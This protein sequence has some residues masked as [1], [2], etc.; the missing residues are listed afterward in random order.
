MPDQRDFCLL[1]SHLKDADSHRDLMQGVEL[2]PGGLARRMLGE[3]TELPAELVKAIRQRTNLKALSETPPS[4]LTNPNRL[5][6]QIGPMLAEMP[7]DQA[8]PA[9]FAIANQYAR[10]GQWNMAREAFLLLIDR[11]PT[12][13]LAM[14]G[15]RWLIRHNSSTKAR[16][17]HELG[18]FV[19]VESVQHGMPV[20]E[21]STLGKPGEA[22]AAIPGI[23]LAAWTKDMQQAPEVPQLKSKENSQV[24]LFAKKDQIR[25]WYQSSLDLEPRLAGFGP[26]LASD[27]A[28]QFCLQASRR[29]LGDFQTAH[30]WY[31]QFVTRQ[32]D[33]PW[34]AAAAAEL[35]L[36]KRTGPSPKPVLHCRYTDT[37]PLLDGKLDESCWQVAPIKLQNATG[38]ARKDNFPKEFPTEVRLAYDKDFLYIALKCTHPAGRFVRR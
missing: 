12:H 20:K 38:D 33:G 10:T 36:T 5:L 4:S 9:A 17:R 29:N 25:Q 14:D 3:G 34:R 23:K 28:L 22:D 1:A 15:F 18:Q 13:P 16:H 7:D 27:P 26:L 6:G 32:P 8:A 24:Y 31:T 37:P 11:Y 30:K 35:W 19:V 21:G 2:A